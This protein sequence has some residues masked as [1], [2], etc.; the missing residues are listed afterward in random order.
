MALKPMQFESHP[1]SLSYEL[2]VKDK[3]NGRSLATTSC[4][5]S[6]K[7]GGLIGMTET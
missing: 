5:N 2:M 7:L 3:L 1:D 4:W 6:K